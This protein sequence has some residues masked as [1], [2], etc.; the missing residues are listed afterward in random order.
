[1]RISAFSE[2]PEVMEKIL[3]DSGL[4]ICLPTAVQ[5]Y[6]ILF[7]SV[8]AAI[9]LTPGKDSDHEDFHSGWKGLSFLCQWGIGC[10]LHN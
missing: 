6:A 2:R 9:N 10:F 8:Q 7:H 4:P 5:S 3:T 1:M